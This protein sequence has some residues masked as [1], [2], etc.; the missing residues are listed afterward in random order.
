M[1]K[2]LPSLEKLMELFHDHSIQQLA[3]MFHVR[4]STV[5]RKIAEAR[6]LHISPNPLHQQRFNQ[7]KSLLEEGKNFNQIGKIL[8]IDPEA[9]RRFATRHGLYTPST[10]QYQFGIPIGCRLCV[11]RPHLRGLCYNCYFRWRNRRKKYPN[12]DLDHLLI[13][14]HPKFKVH[15]H[16]RHG[17]T[18]H[19]TFFDTIH[20]SRPTEL[21]RSLLDQLHRQLL[22][23]YDE[24]NLK[25]EMDEA[26]NADPT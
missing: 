12:P 13:L 26:L 10:N 16:S 1:P 25:K 23:T 22:I 8:S 7:I 17:Y 21:E 24:A 2:K 5:A 18:I 9:A 11:L 19:T 20:I 4:E 3:E 6:R 14:D 15:Y